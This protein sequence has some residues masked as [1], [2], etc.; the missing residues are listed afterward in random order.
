MSNS[1]IIHR[2]PTG[3]VVKQAPVSAAEYAEPQ[4]EARPKGRRQRWA[5]EENNCSW[6]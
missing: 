1:V 2:Q 6:G 4:A 3:R 5:I